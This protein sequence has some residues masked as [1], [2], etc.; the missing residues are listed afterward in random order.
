MVT[1]KASSL[2]ADHRK[3]L[4]KQSTCFFALDQADWIF[5]GQPSIPSSATVAEVVQQTE[6]WVILQG[7]VKEHTAGLAWRD[8]TC[9][10]LLLS[11]S[12]FL[13]QKRVDFV[14]R[15]GVSISHPRHI[16]SLSFTPPIAAHPTFPVTFQFLLLRIQNFS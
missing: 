6:T 12:T 8:G 5:S 13:A 7:R 9:G 16:A 11:I 14:T 4:C 15:R 1:P 2:Q 10:V 3:S